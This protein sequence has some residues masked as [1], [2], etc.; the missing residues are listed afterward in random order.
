MVTLA[1]RASMQLASRARSQ[2]GDKDTV[3]S[4]SNINLQ[5]TVFCPLSTYNNDTYKLRP[6]KLQ[7]LIICLYEVL[8]VGEPRK[9]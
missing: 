7:N 1:A 2:I 5:I 3:S 6:Y 9:N 4:P 8:K